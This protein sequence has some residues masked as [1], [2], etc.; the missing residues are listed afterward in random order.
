MTRWA[1]TQRRAQH[2]NFFCGHLINVFREERAHYEKASFREGFN[3]FIFD[4][5]RSKQN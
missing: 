4:K 3:N 2:N 5:A 1:G